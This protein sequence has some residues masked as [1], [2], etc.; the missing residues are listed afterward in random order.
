MKLSHDHNWTIEEIEDLQAEF[1]KASDEEAANLWN[2]I[3]AGCP[4][5]E[6]QTE[7]LEAFLTQEIGNKLTIGKRDL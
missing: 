7:N 6:I 1:L 5:T 2:T 4:A 3:A